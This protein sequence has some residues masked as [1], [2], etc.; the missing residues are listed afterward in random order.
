MRRDLKSL[1]EDLVMALV[2]LPDQVFVTEVVGENTTVFEVRVAKE[3]V[4]K[5]LGKQGRTADALRTIL[6]GIGG[7]LRKRTIL[8]ICD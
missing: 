4:G 5:V 1:V 7:K 6:T 2:D 3:D 8:E